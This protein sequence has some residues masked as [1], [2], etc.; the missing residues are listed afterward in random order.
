MP[1]SR[2]IIIPM[3]DEAERISA[4]LGALAES[5]LRDAEF[6]LVDDGS[7][8]DSR[9]V[10][11]DQMN[12][13]GIEGKLVALPHR[14]KGAAVVRGATEASGATIVF[15][16]ADL[17]TDVASVERVVATVEQPGI[18]I[19]IGSRRHFDSVIATP[20]PRARELVGRGF[21]LLARALRLTTLRDTQCGLKAFTRHAAEVALVPVSTTGFC[22]DIEVLMTA[23]R[24]GL[25]VVE[26]PVTWSHD[27]ASAVRVTRDIVPVA[28]EL[29]AL[30]RSARRQGRPFSAAP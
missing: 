20:Q 3:F 15:L 30:H 2:S 29:W 4:T 25:T 26:V 21:N 17:S 10:A 18:D 16:D 23:G 12:V 28:R 6:V 9:R 22:F 24:A 7:T 13:L 8:D 27:S 5:S 14:G 11:V 19:A 1:A